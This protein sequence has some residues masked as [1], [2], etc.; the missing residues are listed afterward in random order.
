MVQDLFFR[1]DIVLDTSL[2]D[3][4]PGKTEEELIMGLFE[5][6]DNDL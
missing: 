6:S 5:K 2:D 4:V 3:N 1:S